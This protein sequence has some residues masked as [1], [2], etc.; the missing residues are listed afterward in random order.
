MAHLLRALTAFSLAGFA[1]LVLLWI[2]TPRPSTSPGLPPDATR[3]LI[4]RGE[5]L[6]VHHRAKIAPPWAWVMTTVYL[7]TDQ[8]SSVDQTALIK[9]LIRD[10][11]TPW[12][13]QHHIAGDVWSRPYLLVTIASRPSWKNLGGF[14][15]HLARLPLPRPS[16][17]QPTVWTSTQSSPV[18]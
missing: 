8:R 13:P 14:G 3:L 18:L 2:R 1:V 11:A 15:F 10:P 6:L 5:I 9:A 17:A 12:D 16:L 7:S 4:W